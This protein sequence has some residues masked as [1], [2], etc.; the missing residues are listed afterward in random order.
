MS[1]PVERTPLG[2]RDPIV[3]GDEARL[4]EHAPA[5]LLILRCEPEAAA[6]PFRLATGVDLPRAVG[7]TG[8]GD[9]LEALWLGPDE[10]V[11][12]TAAEPTRLRE[13]L[14]AGLAEQHY[15]LVDVSDAYAGIEIGGRHARNLLAKLV[16]IDLHPRAFAAG[17]AVATM[18]A[19]SSIWLWLTAED[20]VFRLF[21]RRS[22]A[23]HVWC[24]LSDAG[25]EW[26]L[27]PAIPI[28]RVPLQVP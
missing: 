20:P 25:R 27:P 7:T 15:Q 2:H 14:R 11:L 5:G 1:A 22:H 23:D 24:L 10:W 16:T 6:E 4:A 12:I 8:I 21:V 3:V 13:R 26:G 9:D 28:G 17:T 18:L 19:K